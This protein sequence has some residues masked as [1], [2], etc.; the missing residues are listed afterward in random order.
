[1]KLRIACVVATF[2]SLVLSLTQLSIAQTPAQTAS[3]LP[4]LVRFGGT[5]KDLN[6]NPLTGVV[7]ITFALYSEKTGGAALWLETQNV[8]ADSNGHYAVLLGSTKPDGLPA[9]LFTSEQAR[10]VGVQ[11]SEQAEQPR[12]LLVSAPYALKAGDAETIG[13]LPPSAFVLAAPAAI[14]SVAASSPAASTAESVSPATTSDVTTTGGTVNTIPLFSTAT[15]IQ[16][17]I[18]TQTAATAVNVGGK[19]N[20]PATAAATAAK[21]A[22]S[23][24]LDFVAS[25]FSSKTSTAVNQVF[26]WQAEPAA[27]D[28]ASPSGTLNLLYGLGATAPGETGLKLSSKGVFTFATGQTF[29]GTGT[30]TVSS[31]ALAAPASD[32]TVSG[33][34]VTTHGTLNF[35]WKVA[36]TNANTANAIVKRDA[37]GNFSAGTINATNLNATNATLGDLSITS[38]SPIPTY[39][40]S[41][42]S[43][44]DSLWGVAGS[45]T[46][47][48]V[49]VEGETASDG[50]SGV[51]G[52][53]DSFTG[54]SNGVYG[55]ANANGAG[56]RGYNSSSGPGVSGGSGSG[57]AFSSDGHATQP[58]GMG[59]WAKAMVLVDPGNGG[60]QYCFNS[61]IPASQATTPPCGI[62]YSR[63]VSGYYILDFGFQVTD[64]FYSLTPIY[65]TYTA[66]LN[67]I[68]TGCVGDAACGLSTATQVAVFVDNSSTAPDQAFYLIMF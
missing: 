58:R 65:T 4:R 7:G 52:T 14:G 68:L 54:N 26:Q 37:S 31:V 25:S 50:G 63:P 2:L 42:A 18:L 51:Y 10:W 20:L 33:S 21:G 47:N 24:P 29:P 48:A 12:V 66:S 11:V 30:G 46:G 15:N 36:P 22:N 3:A 6:G 27:N 67:N 61:Q 43:D 39:I 59:G 5:V 38:S 34:P 8:T 16:N 1:M 57:Y 60:I 64:R 49:G 28:T 53:A 41:S 19:L 45:S 32:F 56:V 35:A 17:S 44:A 40:Y 55:V 13:G 23:R 62:G 9:D